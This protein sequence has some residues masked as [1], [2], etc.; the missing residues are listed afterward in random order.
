MSDFVVDNSVVMTWAFEDESAD[1]ADAVLESL[2]ISEAVVPAIW[3]LEVANVLVCA[4]RIGRLQS[5]G[6]LKFLELIGQLP[7]V[8]CETRTSIRNVIDIA[9]ETGLS[10][11]DASYLDLAI[12][13]N[14]PWATLDAKLRKA[15]ASA[16]VDLWLEG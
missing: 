9:R 1:Y 4:E 11:Y 16:G 2:E 7:I 13:R 10:A 14:L 12:A 8:L 3:R 5:T 15:A 6:T